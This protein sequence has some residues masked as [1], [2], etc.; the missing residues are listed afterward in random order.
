MHKIAEEVM[1]WRSVGHVLGVRG[2]RFDASVCT[3]P[4]SPTL[5]WCAPRVW[6]TRRGASMLVRM[7]GC[8]F[9]ASLKIL[10]G[11]VLVTSCVLSRGQENVLRRGRLKSIAGY[12]TKCISRKWGWMT[13]IDCRAEN[14]PLPV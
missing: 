1:R 12:A 14:A 6:P 11:K 10:S 3:V 13:D 7:P 5:C 9:A 8:G 2:L 4:L